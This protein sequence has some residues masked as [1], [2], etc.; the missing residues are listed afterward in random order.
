M[1]A[2]TKPT[3][4]KFALLLLVLA[5]AGCSSINKEIDSS[6]ANQNT[7]GAPSRS[8]QTNAPGNTAQ[9]PAQPTPSLLP[10]DQ[11]LNLQANHA[12]GSV[13][14][15][16]KVTFSEDNISLTMAVTNGHD[17]EIVLNDSKD[18]I[19][20]DN[21]GNRYNLSPPPQN[22][23][24]RVPQGSTLEGRF[25]FLGR[26]NPSASSLTF[27]T[28]DKFGSDASFAKS[29]KMVIPSITIKR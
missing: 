19:L 9:P 29:P 11:D 2:M 15:V 26:I 28:N 27:T 24:V 21:L 17:S 7:A 14:R 25:S 4:T 16:T 1:K 10:A 20:R 6:S 5:A 8:A 22:P 3:L 23:E 18:M 13:L 12:N